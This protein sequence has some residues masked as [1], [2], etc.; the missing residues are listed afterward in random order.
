[1]VPTKYEVGVLTEQEAGM[2]RFDVLFGVDGAAA[3]LLEQADLAFGEDAAGGGGGFLFQPEEAVDAEAE[4][5][6][7]PDGAD[8]GRGDAEAGE[9]ELVAEADI[10]VGGEQLGHFEDAVLDFGR[11]L[12]GHA[13]LAPGLGGEAVGAVLF[14][15]GLDFVELAFADAGAFAGQAD[16]FEFLGE[17]EH[18][19][20]GP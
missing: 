12:V 6:A 18:A 2:G 7:L 13:G 19:Q 1:M 5:V 20:G 3:V 8:G 4:A 14:V 16:V 15:G 11:G 10:A 9:A 17:G